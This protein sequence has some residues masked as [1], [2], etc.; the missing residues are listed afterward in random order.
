[1]LVEIVN[2]T[3]NRH[4]NKQAHILPR[5]L[6]QNSPIIFPHLRK[7]YPFRML[8]PSVIYENLQDVF[9]KGFPPFPVESRRPP[10]PPAAQMSS[11][12]GGS[13]SKLQ[14]SPAEASPHRSPRPCS[15]PPTPWPEIHSDTYPRA[16]PNIRS[17]LLYWMRCSPIPTNAT[18]GPLLCWPHFMLDVL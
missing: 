15:D 4:S 13:P 18:E 5:T 6:G 14:P 17:P 12:S 9:F 3:T 16:S 10:R 1:M 2:R 11:G 7:F 8:F